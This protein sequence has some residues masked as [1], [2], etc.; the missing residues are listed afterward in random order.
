[1]RVLRSVLLLTIAT[2]GLAGC[3]SGTLDD[4]GILAIKLL[5]DGA[6]EVTGT[7]IQCPGTCER[8]VKFTQLQVRS[9]TNNDIILSTD[10]NV[11]DSSELLGWLAT[12]RGYHSTDTPC[13]SGTH[14]KVPMVEVCYYAPVIP[15]FVCGANEVRDI[16]LRPV[17]MNKNSLIHWDKDDHSICVLTQPG[18]AQCWED[19]QDI[20]RD[21]ERAEPPVL[22]NP[23]QIATG[24]SHACALDQTGVHCWSGPDV[25]IVTEPSVRFGLRNVEQIVARSY[26]YA[27]ALWEN[28]VTC[29]QGTGPARVPE[30]VAPSNLTRN[31]EDNSICVDDVDERVC[32]GSGADGTLF[33]A[34]VEHR[35]PLE[36]GSTPAGN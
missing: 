29:W 30:L 1:M 3:G 11:D 16:E 19:W 18:E 17:V 22:I 33:G 9:V 31:D 25:D 36:A 14:C 20:N 34:Y 4:T 5:G 12:G 26:L 13:D 7:G 35:W 27:C 21:L 15:S 23:T 10:I 32:W 6:G 24:T 28:T 8:E 2:L